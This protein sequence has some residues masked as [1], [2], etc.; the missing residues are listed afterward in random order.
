[1]P[2]ANRTSRIRAEGW[3]GTSPQFL[4]SWS[5]TMSTGVRLTLYDEKGRV[6]ASLQLNDD[7]RLTFVMRPVARWR[8]WERR[9]FSTWC[10]SSSGGGTSAEPPQHGVWQC[11]SLGDGARRPDRHRQAGA[12]G[13][14]S[15][16][17]EIPSHGYYRL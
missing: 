1:M 2:R 3:L 8:R 17:L 4:P 10:S 9:E 13:A 5:V 14:P 6:A 16:M 15:F 11:P 7:P 12:S